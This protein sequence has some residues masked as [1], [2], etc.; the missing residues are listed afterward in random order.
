LI[1]F[2][3]SA[4]NRQPIPNASSSFSHI[5]SSS[6]FQVESS[7]EQQARNKDQIDLSSDHQSSHTNKLQSEQFT[8]HSI[9]SVE[10]CSLRTHCFTVLLRQDWKNIGM[11]FD[12]QTYKHDTKADEKRGE[13]RREE[14]E[15]AEQ[16]QEEEEW[17]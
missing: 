16:E 4:K 9:V 11:D 13:A 15:E 5:S 10:C 12:N 14:E 17:R 6:W 8:P 7:T 3:L 2:L 1:P